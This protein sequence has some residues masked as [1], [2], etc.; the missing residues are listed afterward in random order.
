[1]EVLLGKLLG[2]IS[3]I[4]MVRAPA[5]IT[6]LQAAG[7]IPVLVSFLPEQ[8]QSGASIRTSQ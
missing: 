2:S 5:V 8:G 3:S 6:A 4:A 7:V 1:M